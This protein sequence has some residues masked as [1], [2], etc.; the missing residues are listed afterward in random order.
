MDQKTLIE[1]VKFCEENKIKY[2]SMYGQTEASPRISYLLYPDFKHK[3]GSIGKAILGGSLSIKN[4]E[5]IY[6]GS[7]IF[8]G[9]SNGFKDLKTF[10][11]SIFLKLVILV[12]K[13][14]MVLFSLQ[15]EVKESPN[16]SE[17]D[18]I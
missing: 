17:F 5:I 8:G 11:K 7:N 6:T 1:I 12:I 9:Y 18:L 16:C 10:K 4:N 14:M 3:I 2:Y 13:I 15:E